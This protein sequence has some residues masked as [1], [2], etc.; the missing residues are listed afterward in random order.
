MIAIT[1]S[2]SMSVKALL[3]SIC[4][5][6][7]PATVGHGKYHNIFENGCTQKNSMETERG[8]GASADK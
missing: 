2:S 8:A 7:S 1:T 4:L 6:P 5:V 3:F